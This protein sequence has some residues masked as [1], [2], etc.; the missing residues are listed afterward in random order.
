MGGQAGTGGFVPSSKLGKWVLCGSGAIRVWGKSRSPS[1]F[2]FLKTHTALHHT[3]I[4]H[5][6]NALQRK[7]RRSL[8]FELFAV[9]LS[10]S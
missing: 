3:K 5:L 8:V 7:A 9:I 4:A 10:L 6:C 2:L 1:L